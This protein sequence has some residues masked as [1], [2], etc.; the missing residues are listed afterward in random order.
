[1]GFFD[2][3]SSRRNADSVASQKRDS[4]SLG[5]AEN[6]AWRDLG[7]AAIDGPPGF[8]CA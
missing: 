3:F 5:S 6:P 4:T 1:M 8:A 7:T 2:G